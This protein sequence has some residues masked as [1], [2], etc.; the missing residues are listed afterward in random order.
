[1]FGMFLLINIAHTRLTGKEWLKPF[2]T[3]FIK[4]GNGRNIGVAL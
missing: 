1:M 2:F 4:Q 3:Q